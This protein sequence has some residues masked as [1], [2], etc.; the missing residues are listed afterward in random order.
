MAG[1]MD[2][3]Q[4]DSAQVEDLAVFQRMIYLVRAGGR[5]QI[6]R[7]YLCAPHRTNGIAQPA[8]YRLLRCQCQ[9][10]RMQVNIL[11]NSRAAGMIR[12][13]QN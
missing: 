13:H 3:L 10:G 5:D 1:N 2:D 9:V 6:I 11:K 4:A 12:M 8:I 7:L